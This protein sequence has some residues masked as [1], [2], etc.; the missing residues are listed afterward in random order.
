MPI[1]KYIYIS[2]CYIFY[3]L[4]FYAQSYSFLWEDL[5]LDLYKNIDE[6]LAHLEQQQYQYELSGQ[7]ESSVT[8]VVWEIL[9][10]QWLDCD[11]KTIQEMESMIS[12]P[13]PIAKIVL[14]CNHGEEDIPV[15]TIVEIQQKLSS[16]KSSFS[17]RAIEKSQQIYQISRIWLYSDGTT[18]NSPF[19]IIIDLQEIDRVI[20]SEEIDYFGEAFPVWDTELDDFLKA[21]KDYLRDR[22]DENE[23]DNEDTSSGSLEDDESSYNNDDNPDDPIKDVLTHEY[24]CVVP[25]II[26]IHDDVFEDIEQFQSWSDTPKRWDIPIIE[27]GYYVY[28]DGVY[29]N[30]ASWWWAPRWPNSAYTPVNDSWNC[31]SFFCIVIEFSMRNQNLLWGW[32]HTTSIESNLERV[33]EHLKKIANTSK[34]QSKMTTNNWELGLIIP[35]LSDMLSGLGIQVQTKPAPILNLEKSSEA[36][37]SVHGDGFTSKNL[38]SRYYKNIGLDY[39]RRNDLDIINKKIYI[40]KALW[41]CAELATTCLIDRLAQLELFQKK[42]AKSNKIISDSI[43]KKALSEDMDDFYDQF[44]ELERFVSSIKDFSESVL[45][46]VKGMKKIP[47]RNS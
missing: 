17:A 21:S 37:E 9:A 5:G 41:E 14:N 12:G 43:D 35:N 13:S 22:E 32:G 15:S 34:V 40:K 8:E 3:S 38:L 7:W 42:L 27:D 26:D 23:N 18:D 11:I 24:A 31:D 28:N 25:G 36:K 47:I 45:S 30:G 4:F 29:S 33:A 46:I 1:T 44:V 16:I 10:R 39:E 6:W 20:F 2:F 19:D